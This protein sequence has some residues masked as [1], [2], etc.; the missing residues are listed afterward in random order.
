[1]SYFD[2]FIENKEFRP[3][4]TT[5]LWDADLK[6]TKTMR[7]KEFE[8]DYRFISEPD[9]PFVSIKNEIQSIKVAT[10]ILP[11]AVETILIQ[12][13][14]LPQ[15]AKFFTAD[16]IRSKTFMII[17]NVIQD[18]SFVAKTLV[19]NLGAEEYEN[20]HDINHLIEIF[21][22]FKDDKITSV[23]VQNGITSYLKDRTFDFK[24]YFEDN[25]ISAAQITE[26]IQKVISENE[27]IANGISV[28]VLA[29]KYIKALKQIKL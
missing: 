15:D 8:A 3:D 13:G 9:I 22:L 7:K 28:D 14:V 29:R 10:D 5:V 4:Q 1:M 24:K 26:A 17:N 6:Q 19:N 27:A 2:Y 11:Y 23:L 21:Q 20:I 18:P 16:A 25:T 12:G